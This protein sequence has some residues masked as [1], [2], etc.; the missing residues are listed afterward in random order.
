M[1]RGSRIASRARR[2][3]GLMETFD[4]EPRGLVSSAGNPLSN[5]R[6]QGID[7]ERSFVGIIVHG[8]WVDTP[9]PAPA[10]LELLLDRSGPTLNFS[11]IAAGDAP[12]RSFRSARIGTAYEEGRSVLEPRSGNR[13]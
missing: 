12:E 13:R 8:A 10:P 6:H 7:N 4:A 2:E 5:N 3:A 9:R 1:T 11:V